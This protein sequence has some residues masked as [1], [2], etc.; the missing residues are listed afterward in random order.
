MAINWYKY[1]SPASF[2]SLAGK[3]I[4]FFAIIAFG[5]LIAG[6]YIGF[7]VAP[8]DFQQGEAYR[9]IFNCDNYWLL[10]RI[11]I[12]SRPTKLDIYTR[13]RFAQTHL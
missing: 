2:Y 13:S 8:T 10:E 9:I 3:M 1:A 5:L 6:L 7:F 4:P 12:A 11:E